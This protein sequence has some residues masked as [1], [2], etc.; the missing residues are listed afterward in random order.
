MT[1]ML[2]MWLICSLTFGKLE[3]PNFEDMARW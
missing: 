2:A 3:L 1:T